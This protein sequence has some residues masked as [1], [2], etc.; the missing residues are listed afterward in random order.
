MLLVHSADALVCA[1]DADGPGMHACWQGECKHH[2]PHS[3]CL[4][5]LLWLILCSDTIPPP[6][7]Q[8][9]GIGSMCVSVVHVCMHA[10]VSVHVY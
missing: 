6:K 7:Q 8:V 5:C 4:P 2:I 10:C 1:V 3:P 9:S